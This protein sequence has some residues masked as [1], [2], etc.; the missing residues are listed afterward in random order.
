MVNHWTPK[1]RSLPW[2]W[3]GFI[4]LALAVFIWGLGYKLSLYDPPQAKSHQIP[5]AKLLSKNEQSIAVQ[6]PLLKNANDPSTAI[7]RVLPGI[8]LLLAVAFCLLRLPFF[9]LR[10]LKT[11]VVR[12]RRDFA[13]LTSFFFRPPPSLA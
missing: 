5:Q 3:L 2:P 13:A 8:T 4:A 11:A 12:A 6:S 1:R 9:R 7:P 10:G